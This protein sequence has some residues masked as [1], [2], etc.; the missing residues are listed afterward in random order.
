MFEKAR[1]RRKTTE[2][3][4][5]SERVE[6][7]ETTL[8][9]NLTHPERLVRDT[10]EDRQVVALELVVEYELVRDDTDLIAELA[11]AHCEGVDVQA[12]R[13]GLPTKQA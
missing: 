10:V 2:P 11:P 6:E 8:K 12:V 13:F 5:S 9:E 1:Q 4:E 7:D 3:G